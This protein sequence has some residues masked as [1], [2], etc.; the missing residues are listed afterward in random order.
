VCLKDMLVIVIG[1]GS[2]IGCV[3]VIVLVCEGVCVVVVDI[4]GEVV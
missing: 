4:N 3:S 1:G 2:G